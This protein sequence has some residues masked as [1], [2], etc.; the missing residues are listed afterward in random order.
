MRV[1]HAALVK[2]GRSRHARLQLIPGKIVAYASRGMACNSTGSI[3]CD[4]ASKP[5]AIACGRRRNLQPKCLEPD[6]PAILVVRLKGRRICCP[7]ATLCT[8]SRRAET[9]LFDAGGCPC[10]VP[11]RI[12]AGGPFACE[13]NGYL[14]V[15]L[16]NRV[17]LKGR[18]LEV[19]ITSVLASKGWSALTSH[20][21]SCL[22]CAFTRGDCGEQRDVRGC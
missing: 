19:R 22:Q 9:A 2:S 8:N 17:L 20:V 3:S 1:I 21:S 18:A 10:T 5:T 15:K 4:L 6:G 16:D 14:S 13:F 7:N 12:L 11:V